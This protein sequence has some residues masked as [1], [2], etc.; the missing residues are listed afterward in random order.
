VTTG[1]PAYTRSELELR[2]LARRSAYAARLQELGTGI[3]DD[4]RFILQT[5]PLS[6]NAVKLTPES[7]ALLQSYL[8][9]KFEEL[10]GQAITAFLDTVYADVPPTSPDVQ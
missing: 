6:A 1:D 7:Q 4:L 3:T 2:W 9:D 8:Q 5:Q 10:V